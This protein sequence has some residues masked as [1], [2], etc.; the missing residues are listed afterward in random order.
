MLRHALAHQDVLDLA[1]RLLEEAGL[2]RHRPAHAHHAG[3]RVRLGSSQGACSR[4]WRAAEPKSHTQ[5]SPLPVSRRSA[6][7]L[8]RAHS[9]ITVLE[10]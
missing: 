9:P 7:S 4:W 2:R 3:E 5:G 1:R 10:T 8:S 6:M